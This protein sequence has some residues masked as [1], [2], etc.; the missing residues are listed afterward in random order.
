MV[1][2]QIKLTAEEYAAAE[3]EARRLGISLTELL[4]RSLRNVLPADD[5]RPWMRY[6]GSVESGDAFAGQN[7]DEL[8]YSRQG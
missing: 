1:R 5:E 6:A 2:T 3:Q 7:V 8:V 4:S